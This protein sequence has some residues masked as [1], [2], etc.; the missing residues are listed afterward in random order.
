[1]QR[2][3]VLS[4][5]RPTVLPVLMPGLVTAVVVAFAATFVSEHYGGPQFLYALL[6][7]MAFNFLADEPRSKPGIDFAGRQVLRFGVALLGVRI[8]LVQ[9]AALGVTP[10]VLVL[11][12]VASTILFGT[13]LS[14]LLRRPVTEGVLSGGAVAICG[15]SAALAISAVLP[16]NEHSQRFT[17]LTVVGVTALSTLAMIVYPALVELLHF[18]PHLAGIFL[19][20]TI[21]D[22]A[23]VVGA[24]YMISPE[25]GDTATFVKLLRV[26]LL[27]PVVLIL[28]LLFRG[29]HDSAK[30]PMFPTFLVG[31]VV[32]L[33]LNSVGL[34]PKHAGDMLSAL[35]RWCL[36]AAIS[37]I[38]VKTSFRDLRELGWQ[39]VLMMVTETLFLA[40][41]IGAGLLML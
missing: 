22:V 16:R 27:V 28:S 3:I 14:R 39:P 29:R 18:N 2:S 37:A 40:L 9:I 19:G 11:I 24:G 33:I 34:V 31:F 23:Q 15:A 41:L 8:T 26:A 35:S 21:H 25:A 30:A 4:G 13:W 20:G 36:V 38:G 32:L 1:M 10:V 17:L 6:F 5:L 12:G 7:G